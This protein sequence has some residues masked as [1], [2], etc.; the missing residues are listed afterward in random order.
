MS[1]SIFEKILEEK[2]SRQ[3][4]FIIPSYLSYSSYK[5]QTASKVKENQNSGFATF[6]SNK[7]KRITSWISRT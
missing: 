2:Q 7:A 6:S 5:T 4:Q 1:K 3:I